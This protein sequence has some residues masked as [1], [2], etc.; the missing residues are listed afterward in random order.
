MVIIGCLPGLT[1]VGLSSQPC[2]SN[3]S[4]FQCTLRAATVAG[5]AAL[6]CVTGAS[7]GSLPSAI[8]GAWVKS[9]ITAAATTPSAAKANGLANS[10]L[11]TDTGADQDTV[12]A[13][14][15]GSMLTAALR[16]LISAVAISLPPRQSR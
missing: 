6:A 9:C 13:L 4:L 14:A 10:W 7:A 12:T 3:F 15:A 11:L 2:T 8:S 1:V 5:Q 16:S